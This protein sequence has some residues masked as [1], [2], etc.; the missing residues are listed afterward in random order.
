VFDDH[1]VIWKPRDI[2]GGD[3]YWLKQ[4]EEGAVLCVCD[5]TGHGVSGAMLT[6][7]VVS[8]FDAIITDKNYKDTADIVYMLDKRIAAILN[9]ENN[10]CCMD[11][12][13]GCDL[14]V[15][16]IANDGS[17]AMSSG[18]MI[19]HTCDGN[20]ATRYKGQSIY[21][22]EG[23]LIDKDEVNTVIIP[24]NIN[25]KYYIA[26]D[27]LSSQI[28]DEQNKM[29]GYDIFESIILENHN[30]EQSVILEKVWDAF[31]KHRGEQPRRDD[32]IVGAISNRQL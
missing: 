4:F 32:V 18:N 9:V 3:I 11:I 12:K 15:L 26:S 31:E 30:E 14:A 28:G 25:N 23:R 17:I 6:M 20:I 22:G 1:S 10:R 27:G 16:Y 29:F 8:A 13:D 21:I 5:C 24:A 19:V 2:V 7:L